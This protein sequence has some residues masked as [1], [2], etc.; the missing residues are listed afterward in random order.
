[1]G[2]AGFV[3]STPC[4]NP[5]TPSTIAAMT[6]TATAAPRRNHTGEVIDGPDR[7]RSGSSINRFV[8]TASTSDSP[9]IISPAPSVTSV[10]SA[11][12]R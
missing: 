2:R 1:M 9:M 4:Q 6:V 8:S 5:E 12:I 7:S 3:I 10:V 11:R